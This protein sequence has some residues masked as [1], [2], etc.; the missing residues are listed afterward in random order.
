[1]QYNA[2]VYARLKFLPTLYAR[3]A[4]V[5][6]FEESETVSG[7]FLNENRVLACCRHSQLYDELL[8]GVPVPLCRSLNQLTA[9]RP[10]RCSRSNVS[11]SR[12]WYLGLISVSA[13]YVS[14]TTLP[15]MHVS[16]TYM[17]EVCMLTVEKVLLRRRNDLAAVLALSPR[18]L[19]N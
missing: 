12:L 16:C 2:T 19:Q 5:T 1:M 18:S 9:S 13:S 15:T 6:L 10:P 11:V 7:S 3:N 8:L 14:F 4:V 17:Y